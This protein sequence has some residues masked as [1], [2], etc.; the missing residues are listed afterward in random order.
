MSQLFGGVSIGV[1][2]AAV[3][4]GVVL[5]ATIPVSGPIFAFGVA[6]VTMTEA[7]AI[8]GG[9]LMVAGFGFRCMDGDC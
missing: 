3:V 2:I 4:V 8:T 5:I 1:G 6:A 9:G 7:A